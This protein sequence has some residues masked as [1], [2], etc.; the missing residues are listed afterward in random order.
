MSII[1]ET[2][3]SRTDTEDVTAAKVT[4]RKNKAPIKIPA[5]PIASKTFGSDTNI[6]PG[7]ADMPSI[8]MKVNTAGIIISPASIATNVSKNS[9]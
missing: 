6:S 9:I 7:P 1:P 5:V 2:I 8:P 3:A 4:I